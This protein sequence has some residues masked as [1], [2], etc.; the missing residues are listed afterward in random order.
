MSANLLTIIGFSGF[1]LSVIGALYFKRKSSGLYS[2]L[3]EGADRFE[4]LRNRCQSM[5]DAG[6]K[7][8]EELKRAKQAK[9]NLEAGIDEARAKSSEL[10]QKLE[11]KEHDAS[12]SLNKFAL[13]RQQFEKLVIKYQVE[14]DATRAKLQTANVQL[15][16]LETTSKAKIQD[17]TESLVDTTSQAAHLKTKLEGIDIEVVNAAKRRVAQLERLYNSMKGLKE[18]A[19]ERNH[20]WERAIRFL[21]TWIVTQDTNSKEEIPSAIGPLLARALQISGNQLIDDSEL[22]GD[23]NHTSGAVRAQN[24]EDESND[25]TNLSSDTETM[26]ISKAQPKTKVKAE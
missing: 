23:E 15:V 14:V 9:S 26:T 4:E 17:L 13:E 5:Q 1:V 6:L 16:S 3:V 12:I 7:L 20:N 25:D 21:S 18:M 11:I 2:L 24:M 10:L 19:E 8:E 22:E